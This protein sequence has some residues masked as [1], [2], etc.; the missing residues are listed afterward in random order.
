MS[1]KHALIILSLLFMPYY[2]YAAELTNLT[3]NKVQKSVA[4]NALIIDIRTPGE[5]KQTGIIPGSHPVTFFDKNGKYDMEKWLADVK[6]LQTSPEQKI[7][8]VC[9]SGRRSGQVGHF[10]AQKLNM[11]NVAHLTHG[12]ASWLKEKRP[13]EKACTALKTC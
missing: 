12:M 9:Q 2:G 1:L 3:P 5:W 7:V 13:T 10:L 4:Q 8:L 11:P 6:K